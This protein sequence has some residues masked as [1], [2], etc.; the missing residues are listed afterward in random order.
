MSSPASICGK[1][2]NMKSSKD[3]RSNTGVATSTK[4]G[5]TLIELLVVIAI[6]A[7]LLSI[8]MP[9]LTK[10]KRMAQ[11]IVCRSNVRQLAI[12]WW[13]YAGDNNEGM[14]GGNTGVLPDRSLSYYG[15]SWTYSWVMP[16]Q[17][18]DGILITVA[19]DVNLENESRGI[20]RGYLYPY[21]EDV[22]VYHCPGASREVLEGG[23]YRTYSITGLMNGELSKPKSFGGFPEHSVTKIVDVI[24]PA[25]KVVFLENKG[26]EGWNKGSWIFSSKNM[27]GQKWGDPIAIWHGKGTVLGFADGHAEM[28]KW[29][30]PTTFKM[31]SEGYQWGSI[32][33]RDMGDEGED[34]KFMFNA[35]QPKK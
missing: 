2:F 26:Q 19:K 6:I 33:P 9:S 10:V 14:V 21:A 29:S 27:F 16:P 11:G 35:Y 4:K 24:R 13:T 12:G 23:G 28:H 5:F 7:L 25:S 30:E 3:F 8:L 20:E 17:L 31:A 15:E 32:I 18:E 1:V 34:I 22:D